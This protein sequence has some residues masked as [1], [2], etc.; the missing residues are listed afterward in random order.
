MSNRS[1][2]CKEMIHD[3]LISTEN[4]LSK[5][6]GQIDAANEAGD[7]SREDEAKGGGLA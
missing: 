6:Y 1:L 2:T 3:E 4:W 5:T 7:Y